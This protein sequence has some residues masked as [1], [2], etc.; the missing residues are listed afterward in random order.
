MCTVEPR[1]ANN[2]ALRGWPSGQGRTASGRVE[3]ASLRS[4]RFP[5]SK[6]RLFWAVPLQNH[7]GF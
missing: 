3:M 5:D 4:E 2:S 7:N 6:K 1:L